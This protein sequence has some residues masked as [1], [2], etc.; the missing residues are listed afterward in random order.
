MFYPE[1]KSYNT[2]V[3]NEKKKDLTE[4]E[5]ERKA[6]KELGR[7]GELIKYLDSHPFKFGVLKSLFHDALHYKKKRELEKGI[8]KF[9]LRALPIALSPISFPVW[10][11]SLILGSTRA[12]DKIIIPCLNTST[13]DYH[14]FLKNLMMKTIT[15]AEGD[16][17]PFL[18]K[19]WYYDA[20][21]IH[22]GLIQMIKQEH[23]YK[24]ATYVADIID[25]K[26]D[27]ELVPNYWLDNQFRTWLNERFST[28]LPLKYETEPTT[29]DNDEVIHF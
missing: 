19:D 5:L 7:K 1:M 27:D 15:M 17:K 24:F 13:N 25:A 21:Y 20:F 18:G 26:P 6:L 10:L 14:S 9:V 23:T 2:F 28:D 4:E 29:K 3:L 12:L 11:V 16:I 22:D 8:A